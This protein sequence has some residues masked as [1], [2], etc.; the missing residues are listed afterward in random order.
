[1]AFLHKN[2]QLQK[3]S[4]PSLMKKIKQLYLLFM[5]VT[6]FEKMYTNLGNSIRNEFVISNDTNS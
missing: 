5:V 1:M 2:N 3:Y 4:L 6:W